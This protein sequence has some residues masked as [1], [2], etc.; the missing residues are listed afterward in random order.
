MYKYSVY[1]TLK[2]NNFYEQLNALGAKIL[3]R[4]GLDG[5]IVDTHSQLILS[6]EIDAENYLAAEDKGWSIFSDYT[7]DQ[8]EQVRAY[9]FV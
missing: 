9:Q 2:T 4:K 1:V 5:R 7:I 6:F 3:H 8:V